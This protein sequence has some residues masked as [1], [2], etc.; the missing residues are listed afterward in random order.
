[1]LRV[2]LLHE[3]ELGVWKSVLLHLI[4]MLHTLPNHT[5]AIQL[6][7]QRYVLPLYLI[8]LGC[9]RYCFHCRPWRRYRAIPSFG[10]GTIRRI[11]YNVSDLKSLAARNLEDILQVRQAAL[12]VTRPSD[13]N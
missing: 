10:R 1:M 5:E 7:N 2:D 11:S 6:L 13:P 3:F 8:L 4:R 12:L 9:L